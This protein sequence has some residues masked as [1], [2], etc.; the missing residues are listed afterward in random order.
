MLVH[1]FII[2]QRG[3]AGEGVLSDC[4]YFVWAK[5]PRCY[6]VPIGLLDV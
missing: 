2:N 5:M 6:G 1:Y 3:V 4:A